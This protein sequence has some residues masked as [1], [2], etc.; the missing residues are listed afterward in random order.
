MFVDTPPA[1]AYRQLMVDS[2]VSPVAQEAQEA[3]TQAGE[4][5]SDAATAQESAGVAQSAASAAQSDATQ[6]LSDAASAQADA[7]QALSDAAGAQSDATQALS[8][9]AGA[10]A[11]ATQSLARVF[12][13]DAILL[14]AGT[15]VYTLA[16]TPIGAVMAFLEDPGG[17][18]A[19]PAMEDFGSP[20]NVR[21]FSRSGA[22]VTVNTAVYTPA[23]GDVAF[24]F[25]MR[26]GVA[27]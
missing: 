7:T 11:D 10:Q 9:A 27:P 3:A 4:A 1:R 20:V 17:S 19:I 13:R 2:A 21:H 18:V 15:T 14:A 24:F 6:A 23:N 8:D 22:T 26:E 25:Y 12:H 16:Y 5:L